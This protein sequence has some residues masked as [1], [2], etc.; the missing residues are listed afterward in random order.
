M[1]LGH[2][3]DVHAAFGRGDDGDAADRAVDQHREIEL[4][5]DVAAFLDVEALDGLA[6]RA[7]LLGDQVMA[8]HGR[9]VLADFLDRLRDAHAALAVGIVL[10]AALAPAAGMDLRLHDGDGT[11][12]LAGHV[13]RLVLGIGH[14][15]LEQ[16]DGE[17]GQQGLGLILVDIHEN[18]L[19]G[20]QL[21]I[22][23]DRGQRHF[24]SAAGPWQRWTDDRLATFDQGLGD[25]P[26]QPS[27]S[28][29]EGARRAG[30]ASGR[31][32]CWWRRS[33]TSR[34]RPTCRT[35]PFPRR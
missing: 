26:P 19:L 31:R 21:Q 5:F 30:G 35:S 1:V 14:A 25:T 17:F 29:G 18:L 3:L 34:R 10:E 4:A 11:A 20:L 33:A 16:R 8:Q 12:E 7:G 15:A 27:P 6:G 13:H 24:M 2:R 28:D 22:A 9:G 23:T 32:S